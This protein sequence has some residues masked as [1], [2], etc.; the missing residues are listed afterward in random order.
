[1]LE[2]TIKETF[3]EVLEQSQLKLLVPDLTDDVVLLESGLDSLG[4]AI[5]VA[6][7]E[8][9][10]GYDPFTMLENPVYPKTFG[11]FLDVYKKMN[12]K[13]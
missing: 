3:F 2:Q 10:L 13:K 6:T 7:L 8:E 11:D 4:F 12:Q 1:M 5:L 9:K